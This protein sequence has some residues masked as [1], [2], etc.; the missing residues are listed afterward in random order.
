LIPWIHLDSATVPGDANQLRLLRRGS[1]F[2]IRLGVAEL[3]NSRLSG[4]EKALADLAIAKLGGHAKPRVLI[5]GLG[6]GFTL[7]A[8]LEALPP[9][10]EIVVA[11]LSPA[12]VRWARGPMAELFG[13]CLSDARVKIEEVDVA[14]A[15]RG[16]SFD[17]IMLDVDNGPEAMVHKGNDALYGAD[18][19]RQ[20]SRALR[21]G[22]V[23]TVWSAHPDTKF[24]I[25]MK[26]AGFAT[27]EV[28]VRA[29]G[30]GGGAKHVIWVG[31]K[32]AR[33]KRPDKAPA[34]AR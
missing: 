12:V 13:E 21:T 34:S 27:Q 9:G 22:G 18:G 14:V 31:V 26:T 7:R 15:I 6:M 3:M 2:S 19:L 24:T 8:A 16:G 32:G 30:K 28:R 23:L 33:D 11:E 10:A 1:E 20:A 5:G 25:R 4:S 29:D 17:A